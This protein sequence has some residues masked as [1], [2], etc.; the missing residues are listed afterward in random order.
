[1]SGHKCIGITVGHDEYY[2]GINLV[3]WMIGIAKAYPPYQAV[4]K[5]EDL[6]KDI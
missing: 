2:V 4:V 3:F 6:R 1:L 5:T